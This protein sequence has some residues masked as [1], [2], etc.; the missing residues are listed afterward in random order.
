MA[1][2]QKINKKQFITGMLLAGIGV[3]IYYYFQLKKMKDYYN[4]KYPEN[5]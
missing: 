1:T 3:T 2:E 4:T 5:E